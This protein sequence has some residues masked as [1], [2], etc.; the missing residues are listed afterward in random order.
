MKKWL[1]SLK[2]SWDL[3]TDRRVS[4]ARRHELDLVDDLLRRT[5]SDEA[6]PA[7]DGMT[8]RILLRVDRQISRDSELPRE[9]PARRAFS[10]SGPITRRAAGVAALLVIGGG[11]LIHVRPF[12]ETLTYNIYEAALSD[13]TRWP[14]RLD[15]DRNSAQP[16]AMASTSTFAPTPDSPATPNTQ[17]P[18][19]AQRA[20]LLSQ[21]FDALDLP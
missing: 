20:S 3:D 14:S 7:P 6:R 19:S 2:V 21:D 13:H 15:A 16:P 1:H 4:G 12:V 5:A 8:R 11:V 17:G 18:L 9:L 10:W